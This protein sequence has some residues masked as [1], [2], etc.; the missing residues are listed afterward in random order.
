MRSW[1]KSLS[2][3]GPFPVYKGAAPEDLPR[4]FLEHAI[5][6]SSFWISL[7]TGCPPSPQR[8]DRGV[9]FFWPNAGS[10]KRAPD[11]SAHQTKL[12]TPRGREA[13]PR[14]SPT[15]VLPAGGQKSRWLGFGVWSQVGFQ[16][17]GDRHV[18]R[19]WVKIMVRFRDGRHFEARSSKSLKMYT[20][21]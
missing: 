6:L 4:A 5:P 20:L 11:R 17:G 10:P 16:C 13:L 2:F 19:G 21:G 8:P 9:R 12:E 3:S 18:A 7:D 1:T 15:R 14:E